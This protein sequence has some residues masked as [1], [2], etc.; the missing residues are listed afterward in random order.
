MPKNITRLVVCALLLTLRSPADAQQQKTPVR[1][2]YL[3]VLSPNTDAGRL[4]AFRQGMRE[5]GYVDGQNMT[6]EPRY[7]EGK[8][9]RL[10]KLAGELV[11]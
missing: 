5:Q 8:L 10:P 9:D 11:R 2:G 4:E 1:I 3:S 6:I 7:A